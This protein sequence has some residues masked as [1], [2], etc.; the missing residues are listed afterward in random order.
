MCALRLIVK[1]FLSG[2]LSCPLQNVE[3]ELEVLRKL[4]TSMDKQRQL[5]TAEHVQLNHE[6]T[7]LCDDL[8]LRLEALQLGVNKRA[9][10]FRIALDRMTGPDGGWMPDSQS[11][12]ASTG[13][14]IRGGCPGF[15]DWLCFVGHQ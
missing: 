2:L 1:C 14:W 6:V 7:G 8:R 10:M 15:W 3:N 5:V 12:L 11:K 9:K 4:N 13:C